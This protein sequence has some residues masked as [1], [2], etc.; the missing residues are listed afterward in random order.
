MNRPPLPD[1]SPA[2]PPLFTVL[3]LLWLAGVTIRMPLLAV[4]TCT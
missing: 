4:T 3:S 2:S 1:E